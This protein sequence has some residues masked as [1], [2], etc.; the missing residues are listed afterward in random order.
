M[1]SLHT[2]LTTLG[3]PMLELAFF[4]EAEV[5]ASILP[6]GAAHAQERW[7]RAPA[8]VLRALSQLRQ[9]RCAYSPGGRRLQ[10]AS[11][12]GAQH[13]QLSKFLL[14]GSDAFA[15]VSGGAAHAEAQGEPQPAAPPQQQEMS[16]VHSY[17]PTERDSLKRLP[18]FTTLAGQHVAI[19]GGDGEFFTLA[20]HLNEQLQRMPE[21]ATLA[22]KESKFHRY[23][24]AVAAAVQRP[25]AALPVGLSRHS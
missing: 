22:E 6:Q 25:L 8:A 5:A 18:L 16:Q 12:S 19:S 13:H 9:L 20:Q 24:H 14:C 3:V 7:Q 2:L 1:R 23:T 4:P 11:L 10:W 17:S 15:A 21:R